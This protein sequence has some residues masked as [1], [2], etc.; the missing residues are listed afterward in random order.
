MIIQFPF[1]GEG[2][3]QHYPSGWYSGSNEAKNM[4]RHDPIWRENRIFHAHLT[5]DTMRSGRSAK[6]IIWEDMGTGLLYPMFI[7]DLV[8]GMK[9]ITAGIM[10]ADFTYCKR[11]QNY[12]LRVYGTQ[13]KD[14]VG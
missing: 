12:G 4:V 13:A 11:G 7:H 3:L 5:C 1:D 2:N 14:K 6:Y 8:A 10:E 9:Y